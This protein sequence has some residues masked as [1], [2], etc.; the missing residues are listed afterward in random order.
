MDGREVIVKI[1]R[2]GIERQV[3]A[4]LRILRR[5]AR[6]AQRRVPTV[7]RLRPDELLRHL[8]ENLAR[9]M[10]L[11]AE[12]RSSESIGAFLATLGVRTAGFE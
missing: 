7:A 6:L 4:D 3:D 9:E 8:G 10:D 11:G 2:P 5:L 12:A 1:R